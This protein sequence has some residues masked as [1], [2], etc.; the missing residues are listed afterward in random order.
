PYVTTRAEVPDS[1]LVGFLE[2]PR[3]STGYAM[4]WGTL[5]FV[6][7]AHMLKPF[8]ERVAATY[9]ILLEIESWARADRK[10]IRRLRTEEMERWQAADALPV[11][12]KHDAEAFDWVPFRGGR[13][14]FERVAQWNAVA[15]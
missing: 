2:T 12:W 14:R 1:G 15:L 9:A 7:E 5:G 8:P 11:R 6:T 4:L 3:Y 10:R 13:D